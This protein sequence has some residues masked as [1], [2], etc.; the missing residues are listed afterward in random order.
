MSDRIGHL[1]ARLTRTHPLMPAPIP[2]TSPDQTEGLDER[3]RRLSLG[4]S[5]GDREALGSLYAERFERTYRLAR[6]LTGR[7]EAFCLDIVQ[8]VFLRAARKMPAMASAADVE[9]WLVRV[10]HTAAIDL[11]RKELREHERR[12]HASPPEHANTAGIDAGERAKWVA[13]QL[14]ALDAADAHLLR[15]RFAMGHTLKETGE[16]AG[17]TGAAAHGRLRRLLE[18]LRAAARRTGHE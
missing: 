16:A 3:A 6:R 4:I 7:D 12:E 1:D 11:L 14:A 13:E 17:T 9:R 18:M 5:R 15:S 2:H 10:T 8:E